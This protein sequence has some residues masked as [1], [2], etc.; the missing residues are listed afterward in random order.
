MVDYYDVQLFSKIYVG[1]NKQPFDLI[2]DTGSSVSYIKWPFISLSCCLFPLAVI[3]SFSC[4]IFS[5]LAAIYPLVCHLF[6]LTPVILSLTCHILFKCWLS[7]FGPKY[8]FAKYF[9]ANIE[10]R[11]GALDLG[12]NVINY[13]F[14]LYKQDINWRIYATIHR[15]LKIFL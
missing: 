7:R 5:P 12:F 9:V 15:A 4:C 6:P 14:K 10:N 8:I 1:S 11:F 3:Y 2:L 13:L